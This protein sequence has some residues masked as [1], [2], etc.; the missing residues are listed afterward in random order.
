[1]AA[2]AGSCLDG[3]DRVPGQGAHDD[4]GRGALMASTARVVCDRPMCPWPLGRAHDLLDDLDTLDGQ[5]AEGGP[6]ALMASTARVE[7]ESYRLG[8]P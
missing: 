3:Q 1:M 6:G 4:D 2:G 8:H 7:S 5:G